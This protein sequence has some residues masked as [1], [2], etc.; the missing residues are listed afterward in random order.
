M[1]WVL[2]LDKDTGKV[3]AECPINLEGLNYSP[4]E[5]EYFALAW[6][7]AV[8]DNLVDSNCRNKYQFKLASN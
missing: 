6:Q 5:E 7:T 1:K 2:I 3:V 4:K 8:E